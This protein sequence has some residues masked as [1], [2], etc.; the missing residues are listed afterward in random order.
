MVDVVRGLPPFAARPPTPPRERNDTITKLTKDNNAYFN[1][2]VQQAVLDS[3]NDSPSSSGDYFGAS[4]DR[5]SKRVVFSPWTKY[6]KPLSLNSKNTASDGNIRSL[7]PSR[8]CQSSKSILKPYIEPTITPDNEEPLA[9][10]HGDIP[11]MLRSAAQHLAS[12]LRSSRLDAY[13]T[14]LGCLS[15]YSDVPDAQA[16]TERLIELTEYIRRD[17]SARMKATGAADTQLA[18]QALKLLITVLHTGTL[19]NS[20]PE[21]F[22]SHIIDRSIAAIEDPETPKI[23]VSHYMQLLVKQDFPAQVMSNDRVGR[24]L[25]ALSKVETRVNGS[26][27]IGHRLMIYQRLLTQSKALMKL[28]AADWMEHLIMG[29][30]AT[31]K[32][33]RSR[34]IAFGLEA[35]LGLGTTSTVSQACINIFNRESPE[36]VKVVDF[37]AMRLREMVKVKDDG[38]HVPQIWSIAILFL[39]S[40]RRQIERWEHLKSWLVI[41]QQ[42]F[43]SSDA[44]IK[45]QAN[46][47]WNRLI[48]AVS[49]DSTTAPS[50]MKTL[51]QPIIAQLDRKISD[52]QSKHAKQIARSAYCNLLY[53]VF[54]PV[55][56][57]EQLDIYWEQSVAQ[58]I[59]GS[60]S[61]STSD[62]NYACEILAA[63]FGSRA[64]KVWNENRA[65][66]GGPTK[67]E[68][69]PFLDPRW[70]R[71]RASTILTTLEKL[72]DHAD[73]QL[74]TA[75]EASIVLAWRA[76]VAAVGEAGNKEVKVSMDSMTAVAHILTTTK[77]FWERTLK[78]PKTAGGGDLSNDLRKFDILIGEAVAMIGIMPFT[79]KR[80]IQNSQDSFEAAET[81]SSRS[82]RQQGHLNTPVLHLLYMIISSLG[83]SPISSAHRNT[84]RNLLQIAI[85]PATSRRSKLI[86][87]REV[88]RLLPSE[89]GPQSHVMVFLW[90]Q[91]AESARSAIIA[92]VVIDSHN[93]GS[94]YAGHDY[95]DAVKILEAG[96]QQQSQDNLNH[97]LHLSDTLVGVVHREVGDGG[98]VLAFVEPLAN[99]LLRQNL[100]TSDDLLLTYTEILLKSTSWPQ[101]HHVME[102]AHKALWGTSSASLKPQP[103]DPLNNVC[104]VVD[105]LLSAMYRQLESG[106][107][108]T[109]VLFLA[110]VTALVNVCP[111]L[112]KVT[113]LKR[114]QNGLSH[115]I[116]D[117]K[118]L[119]SPVRSGI[120]NEI[121]TEVSDWYR[122]TYEP[123]DVW[124]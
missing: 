16:L 88:T 32:D 86:I 98:V 116:E 109:M 67:P 50:L 51:R 107:S 35:G 1:D 25:S 119:I 55:P 81:P 110:R 10:G 96:M 74:D 47:A 92:A 101:S 72:L 78:H 117:A 115:W 102:R 20:I 103:L 94:Q 104:T 59:A 12:P 62:T 89:D 73:W 108:A 34:A 83:D 39:R 57:F 65:N 112:C 114:I 33:T 100:S 38:I 3:P 111:L 97:W 37:L 15:A 113:L 56:T 26:S 53:Y 5:G 120:V 71:R 124:K 122:Y 58:I 82:I 93:D 31:L 95:R 6:H 77:R 42:C 41:M 123:A 48:Y 14:I 36:G 121:R 40:R 54:R 22:S 69:L 27:V 8:Y 45:F 46:I 52:K 11:T 85:Q 99:A 90:Q 87:L 23:L 19:K 13:M 21:E 60:F 68:D 29:M 17:V 61:T 64:P 63:L 79:E 84:I 44:Q 2:L 75:Q 49:P 43:N 66:A 70:I 80:L 118:I 30:L 9:F 24:L 7:P 76:F 4:S 28:R 91:I 18:T 106:P 105:T